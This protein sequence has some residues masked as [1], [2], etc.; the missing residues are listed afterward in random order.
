MSAYHTTYK[1]RQCAFLYCKNNWE[2]NPNIRYF[3]FP[4]NK[5]LFEKWIHIVNNPKL[6]AIPQDKVRHTYTVCS[7]HF[8][9]KQYTTNENIKLN[10]GAVPYHTI[11]YSTNTN[12][13]EIIHEG[14][15]TSRRL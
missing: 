13:Q 4:K 8:D 3:F 7:D 12:D 11:S 10:R 14:P 2:T 15:S 6:M 1:F 9:D 5:E